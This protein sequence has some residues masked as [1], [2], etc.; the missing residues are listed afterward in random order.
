MKYDVRSASAANIEADVVVVALNEAGQFCRSLTA[1]D[2]AS[3]GYF[4][5][6][7]EQSNLPESAG[8]TM[9]FVD[10]SGIATS[11]VLV[12]CAEDSRQSLEKAAN[13][14]F[15]KLS[16]THWHSVVMTLQEACADELQGLARVTRAI[17]NANYRFD[18]YKTQKN[19]KAKKQAV[20]HWTFTTERKQ[21]KAFEE[22]LAH[23]DAWAKGSAL[24]RDLGNLPPNVCTPKYLG[25]QAE[26]LAEQYSA[27]KVEVLKKKA[28]KELKMGAL[29]GVAQGSKEDPR[30]IIIE[31]KP[32]KAVNKK[33]IVLVGKGVTFDSG[34]ISLKP[35]AAMDEMKYD[36]G[37]AAA[38]FGTMKALCERAL[39]LHVV[40]LIPTVENMPDG[41]ATRP[42]DILTSM[43]GKTIEVLNTDAEGRLILC[44]ALT[45][46]ERYEP[47]AVIDMATL[48]GACVIALGSHRAGLMGND[49]A[50]QSALFD[51]GEQ[52]E[53]PV[54]RLPL[55]AEYKAQLESP[56]ADLQNIG[57]REAGTLTAG[58]FLGAFAEKYPW[59]HL[60]IAGVAWRKGKAKGSTGRPVGLLLAYFSALAS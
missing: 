18:A 5:Q 42:G 17:A 48:T 7:H 43:S 26:K 31:H 57:G 11:R 30:F 55:D 15:S 23:I 50:L 2:E 47:Q 32:K 16:K 1:L 12:V 52:A 59:A 4:S 27:L 53:D 28:I 39:P 9:V 20:R 44:D 37:G 45:Y 35:G 25:H 40:A 8:E 14:V 6:Q 56:F 49:D 10:V 36:M 38:V 33:P 3:N 58:A 13:A 54:W 51:A 41:G 29:L 60:D 22:T 46:A 24:T 19:K 34:G 21:V